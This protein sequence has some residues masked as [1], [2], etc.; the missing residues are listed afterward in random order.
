QFIQNNFTSNGVATMP[1]AAER[2]GN[3]GPDL[4]PAFISPCHTVALGGGQSTSI[5]PNE[6]FDP[7][8][9]HVV[10]GI[11]VEN[12][13]PNNVIP[14]SRFDPTALLIQNLFPAPNNPAG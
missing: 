3:F 2:S 4:V 11:S 10:N 14:A 8:T 1:T 9:R 12:P 7:T 13:F 6:I 5:C